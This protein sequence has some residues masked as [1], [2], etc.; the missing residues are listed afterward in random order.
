MSE[1]IIQKFIVIPGFF[2][3]LHALK[4]TI[5]TNYSLQAAMNRFLTVIV[6]IISVLFLGACED[7]KPQIED[8]NSRL[9]ALEGTK[10]PS[11]EQQ[12]Q[13]IQTSIGE[14]KEMDKTLKGY[15]DVLNQKDLPE[16][17]DAI[18]HLQAKDEE[19]EGKIVELQNFIS[20][21]IGSQSDWVTVT[22]CT[23]EQYQQLVDQLA[24]FK[25]NM[26]TFQGTVNDQLSEMDGAIT[27]LENSLKAW[28]TEAFDK[29]YDIS[30]VN[31]KL[32]TLYNT[33]QHGDQ[34]NKA[35]IDDLSTRVDK[36]LN[37]MT[38]AYQKAISEAIKTNNGVINQKIA[39]E[40]ETVNKRIDDEVEALTKRL[41][42]LEERL[43]AVED[44]VQGQKDFTIDFDLPEAMVCYPGAKLDIHFTLSSSHLETTVECVPDP[45]W[46]ADVS[47]GKNKGDIKITAPSTGGDGKILVFANRST[48][49]IMR[50]L[51]IE[52]GVISLSE[53]SYQMPR[54]GG[55]LDVTVTTNMAYV[56]HFSGITGS[57]ISLI[58]ETKATIREDVLSFQVAENGE[59]K[60][61][62]D[63]IVLL[64]NAAGDVLDA[65]RVHQEGEVI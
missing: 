44:Y 65:I 9:T 28:V 29:Y 47:M 49:T 60:P 1:V 24:G 58:P 11:I 12:I 42:N 36:A 56:L 45:G 16:L 48:W 43:K 54:Q 34:K 57:W 33:L 18:Q 32:E 61:E 2:V 63:G 10:I 3:S 52:Q 25:T 38:I 8:L 17:Q 55:R 30:A 51:S 22:Y 26:D 20:N 39:D 46:K 62:R 31:A 4:I 13:A 53:K 64:M 7:L 37:D 41:D 21:Q 50:V 40:I 6:L 59:G 5:Q 35:A 14:L 27:A 19:L 23:L 15:I